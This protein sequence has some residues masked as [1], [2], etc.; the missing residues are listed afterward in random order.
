[1]WIDESSDPNRFMTVDE[2]WKYVGTITED[3]LDYI[4]LEAESVR[5]VHEAVNDAEDLKTLLDDLA[6]D[7]HLDDVVARLRGLLRF[8]R[9]KN[10]DEIADIAN[11][12]EANLGHVESSIDAIENKLEELK[13]SLEP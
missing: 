8:V 12:L 11:G 2:H 7:L 4:T 13:R 6:S 5:W 9:G 1:M 3:M 10:K